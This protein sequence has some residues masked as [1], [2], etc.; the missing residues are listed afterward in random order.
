[1]ARTM[2]YHII[3]DKDLVEAIAV[4]GT[5]II[6]T[7]ALRIPYGI[8]FG[9]SAKAA[10]SGTID[11][12]VEIQQ[13]FKVPNPEGIA[14]AHWSTPTDITSPI[15]SSITSATI[16]QKALNVDP[17]VYCRFKITGQGSNDTSTTLNIWVSMQEE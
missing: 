16:A 12:K 2:N 10:S 9:I 15:F 4:S 17:F 11:L 13:S 1:M 8:N 6:Y 7:K 5:A 3:T 14:D